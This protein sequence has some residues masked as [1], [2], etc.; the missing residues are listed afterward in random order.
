VKSIVDVGLKAAFSASVED[1][2][3]SSRF[4]SIQAA[5]LSKI[6]DL[7]QVFK[8]ITEYVLDLI[9]LGLFSKQSE[10]IILRVKLC[11]NLIPSLNLYPRIL[12]SKSSGISSIVGRRVGLAPPLS[13]V[14]VTTRDPPLSSSKLK[15]GELLL[16]IA[17]SLGTPPML[18]M[19]QILADSS[20]P[21][22]RAII[23]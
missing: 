19:S 11:R 4:D 2:L 7:S 13:I 22:I 18:C 5:S 15:M 9:L 8:Q 3:L 20:V 16:A 1:F 21:S 14:S 17:A 23:L 6:T 12:L 10:G